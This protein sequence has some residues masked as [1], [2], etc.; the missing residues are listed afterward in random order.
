MKKII[1]LILT[2][3]ILMAVGCS[4]STNETNQPKDT[5]KSENP[6]VS[7]EVTEIEFW[8][9]QDLHVK[10]YELMAEKWNA[11]NPDKQIKLIPTVYPF[12]DMHSKLLMALQSGK[13]APD[14]VDIEAGKFTHNKKVHHTHEGSVGNLC[15]DKIVDMMNEVVNNFEFE[16]VENAEKE[17]LNI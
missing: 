13:G 16:R 2:V 12:E 5:T 7:G 4:K 11:A 9:F 1:A 8:T 14:L 3:T 6:A 10:H 17:L 15:N